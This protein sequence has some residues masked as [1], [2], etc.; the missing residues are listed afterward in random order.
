MVIYMK[1]ML[2]TLA[3]DIPNHK[4]W[5]YETKYDGFRAILKMDGTAIELLS[6]N[7]R[8]LMKQFPEIEFFYETHKQ[9]L[10]P[11]FPLL[12]D[13]ELT[14]LENPFK[15]NFAKMQARGRMRSTDRIDEA[16]KTDKATFL[17]FDLL[18]F[19]GEILTNKPYVERKQTL[20]KLFQL[21]D[22][23]LKPTLQKD[24]SI[25]LIPFEEQFDQLWQKVKQANGE[26]IIAKKRNSR[27]V[28]GKRTKEW[29]KYKNWRTVSCFIT[30][31]EK[32]N[33]FSMYLSI[34]RVK[35][36]QLVCLK[37]G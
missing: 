2:P 24:K 9:E 5:V 30:S 26:G 6:R 8:S 10:A 7:N 1:P 21:L 16:M 3:F 18:I 27:W 23:P 29:M 12:L 22:W 17:A 13:G 36:F 31:Y 32:D 14:I 34:R 25:Q 33:G 20:K 35:S 15:S 37:M 19:K 11:Y 28:E 4:D